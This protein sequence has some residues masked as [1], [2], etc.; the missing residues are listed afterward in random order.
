MPALV[1]RN[2]SF[3]LVVRRSTVVHPHIHARRLELNRHGEIRPGPE[4]R[5]LP[6]THDNHYIA[7]VDERITICSHADPGGPY[8]VLLRSYLGAYEGRV[9][10]EIADATSCMGMIRSGD[11]LRIAYVDN[12]GFGV[13]APLSATGELLGGG[14]SPLESMPDIE[15][16][17]RIGRFDG[18]WGWLKRST[19][20]HLFYVGVEHNDGESVQAT[21]EAEE[22]AFYLRAERWPLSDGTL[23]LSYID[24]SDETEPGTRHLIVVDDDG[25]ERHRRIAV[26]ETRMGWV[27]PSMTTIADGL[28]W[29]TSD[30]SDDQVRYTVEL[31]TEG[32]ALLGDP[33]NFTEDGYNG[34]TRV[35]IAAS[36][37]YIAVAWDQTS[38][39]FTGLEE[40]VGAVL[41][42]ESR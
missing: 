26:R 10:T 7:A 27:E 1:A 30:A 5:V 29:A 41:R 16:I 39:D 42:C 38:A 22:A 2:D 15:S 8:R 9:T 13:V 23:A 19:D 34:R 35:A 3:D 17:I 31:Y 40:I 32:A 18:G 21:Y 20:R 11:G 4:Q 14:F 28:L 25:M 6:E 33:I 37:G 24:T 12:E 36:S